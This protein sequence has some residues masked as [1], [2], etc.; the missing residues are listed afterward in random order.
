VLVMI[1]QRVLNYNPDR[2]ME[3]L[4]S[5]GPGRIQRAIKSAFEAEPDNAFT[6]E[7]LC[8][9]VYGLK[10]RNPISKKQ[11][12]AVLRAAKNV[13]GLEYFPTLNLGGQLVFY[14]PL[15]L[16]SYAMAEM[17]ARWDYRTNDAR[18]SYWKTNT[19]AELRAMLTE[20]EYRKLIRKDGA[21][22]RYV[23]FV[24]AKDRGDRKRA[25]ELSALLWH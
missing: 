8:R 21:W 9:R 5:K 11:R 6:T 19:E 24:K 20:P 25:A 2:R 4:M 13:L 23:E 1:R 22:W 15:N 12:V 16:M 3:T 18:R 7:E 10:S 17:K 14:Q